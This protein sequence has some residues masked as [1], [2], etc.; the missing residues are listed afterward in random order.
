MPSSGG[1]KNS[2]RTKSPIP[3]NQRVPERAK[4]PIVGTPL[5][6]PKDPDYITLEQATAML[7]CARVPG[8]TNRESVRTRILYYDHLIPFEKVGN[9]WWVSMSATRQLIAERSTD[10]RLANAATPPLASAGASEASE[11]QLLIR[12]FLS[13]PKNDYISAIAAGL[14]RTLIHSKKVYEEFLESKTGTEFKN[15]ADTSAGANGATDTSTAERACPA[16]NR[17][18]SASRAESEGVVHRVTGNREAFSYEEAAKLVKLASQFKCSE[19]L[20]WHKDSPIQELQDCL[21]AS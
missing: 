8:Y 14:C 11:D 2:K 4:P 7:M 13:D 15:Q 3:K 1:G 6:R 10:P 16:C 5:K 19:C 18:P 12:H 9:R 21:A 17:T 20:G